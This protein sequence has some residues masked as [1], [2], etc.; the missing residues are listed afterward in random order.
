MVLTALGT[1]VAWSIPPILINNANISPM[2]SWIL[3]TLTAGAIAIPF[4]LYHAKKVMAVKREKMILLIIAAI[5]GPCIGYFLYSYSI[6]SSSTSVA[7][8]MA[9]AFSAPLFTLLIECFYG[10]EISMIETCGVVLIV[11]GIFLIKMV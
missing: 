4:C 1:A 9:I 3:I 5:I 8:T 11:V 2:M 6:L 10:R 7:S